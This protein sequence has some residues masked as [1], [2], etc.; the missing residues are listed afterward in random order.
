MDS[1]QPQLYTTV[2]VYVECL[3]KCSSGC[4][5]V[6]YLQL[7][8]EMN[9]T[10]TLTLNPNPNPSPSPGSVRRGGCTHP[11]TAATASRPTE[12][13]TEVSA[14]GIYGGKFKRRRQLQINLRLRKHFT[15]GIVTKLQ[16]SD[17]KTNARAASS[18][19]VRLVILGCQRDDHDDNQRR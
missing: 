8:V 15:P 1:T 17:A 12:N 16:S 7:F 3:C 2:L 18:N 4:G 19:D 9:A 10:L 11:T 13:S 6:F 14:W 5:C